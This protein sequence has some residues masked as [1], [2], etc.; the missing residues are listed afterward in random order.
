M[1]HSEIS[2]VTRSKQQAIAA[3][4]RLSRWYDWLSSGSERPLAELGLN[5]LNA[6]AGETVLE[7]GFGTG[8]ILLA[9]A[10]AVSDS[11]RVVGIDISRGMV[12]TAVEKIART[13]LSHRITLEQGDAVAL[14][15][16]AGLFDA[17]FASFA[18]EL[19]D[20]PEI[21]IVLSECRR[22]LK[23]G[24]RI[25]VVA[26]VRDEHE[27]FPQH[28]YEWFHRHLPAYVDCR[29]IF[30]QSALTEAGFQIQEVVRKQMWGLPVEICFAQNS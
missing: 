9:L 5:K 2:R 17:I 11:G 12:K 7:I 8:H 27:N 18:L 26:M 29:P 30:V 10:A 22:V 4:D 25:C 20:S 19:F 3:Y 23:T 21:T 13:K 1:T 6:S 24:G 15:H 28:I 16:E 14:P